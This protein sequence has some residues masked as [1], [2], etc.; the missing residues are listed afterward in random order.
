MI[1]KYNES[2][3][4]EAMADLRESVGWNRMEK[5][6]GNP[7]MTSFFH[8]AVYDEDQLVGY[9]DSVSNGFSFVS[10]PKVEYDDVTV[11]NA[12]PNINGVYSFK[13][14]AT[15]GVNLYFYGPKGVYAFDAASTP[16]LNLLEGL[17]QEVLSLGPDGDAGLIAAVKASNTILTLFKWDGTSWTQVTGS[18]LTVDIDQGGV[19]CALVMAADDIWSDTKHW[20][21]DTWEDH[22]FG[23]ASFQ[24]VSD[25]EAYGVDSSG[26]RWRY[27]GSGWT[28]ASTLSAPET[29]SV[30]STSV[31]GS[32]VSLGQDHN[33]DWY[34]FVQSRNHFI[35]DSGW[36][37]Y[38]GSD[39]YKWDGS[40]W[41]Y[42][43]MSDF[44][45]PY[46]DPM[47]TRCRIRPD[48]VNALTVPAPGISVMYG[49]QGRGAIY[50]SADN[51]SI[52]FNPGEGTLDNA[53]L[54]TLTAPILSAI[55]SSKVP[56]ASRDGYTFG[57]WYYD[58]HSVVD[59][60]Y[61]WYMDG[62]GH[63]A[64]DDLLWYADYPSGGVSRQQ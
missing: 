19:K 24:R 49:T 15:K 51:V 38:D 52:T 13:D 35:D 32:T 3:S 50:L 60:C 18:A 41:V 21:G 46:D 44:N 31:N 48:G 36:Y 4:P 30:T 45:D 22:S 61:R 17:S 23:F 47:E 39:V 11:V 54:G 25:T 5:E 10:S 58:D 59:W 16:N 64:Y 53:A 12:G 28:A 33:G 34:L 63:C 2:I 9:V 43:I 37:S 1:Y 29:S 6:Y 26:S 27:D 40:R 57:G 8:I 56:G 14:L 20:N 42:Q 7:L 55:D 62:R